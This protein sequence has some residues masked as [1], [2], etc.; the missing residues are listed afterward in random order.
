MPARD[1]ISYYVII[2]SGLILAYLIAENLLSE[3]HAV[4][5]SSQKDQELQLLLF[6]LG[7]IVFSV[8]VEIGSMIWEKLK[9]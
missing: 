5:I 4:L 2:G 9:T 8:V 7:A 6:S 1:I 3:K